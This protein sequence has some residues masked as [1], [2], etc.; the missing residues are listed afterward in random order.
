MLFMRAQN[1]ALLLSF[2]LVSVGCSTLSDGGNPQ[3]SSI[4]AIPNLNNAEEL[5]SLTP[6]AAIEAT[7]TPVKTAVATSTLNLRTPPPTV[8]PY[9]SL[10]VE[11]LESP[12]RE[13]IA[14]TTFEQEIFKGY[15]VQ[16][17]VS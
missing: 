15:H 17:T 2:L 10:Q 13:W 9:H 12:N 14:Q 1:Y 3:P 16:F 5:V 4:P 6:S 11:S 7:L 8:N